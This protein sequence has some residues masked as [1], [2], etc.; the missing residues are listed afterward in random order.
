MADTNLDYL[1]LKKKSL[2]E[3]REM[4][5][6]HAEGVSLLKKEQLIDLL[7]KELDISKQIHAEGIDVSKIKRQIRQLKAERQEHMEQKN[8]EALRRSRRKIRG[9]KRRIR[10][11]AIETAK[12]ARHAAH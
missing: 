12:H 5:K 10:K 7:C 4:A 8:T 1:T 9:L 3:L 11:A 6:E 2:D